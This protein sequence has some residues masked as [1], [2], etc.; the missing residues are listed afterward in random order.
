MG[1]SASQAR[2]LSITQRLSDN[3]LHSEILANSKMRLADESIAA[4]NEYLSA[5]DATKIQYVGFDGYGNADTVDLTFNSLMTYSEIK[6]QNVL[7]NSNGQ[8][9]I[10]ETDLYNFET[11]ADMY[12]FVS[13][14]C[15]AD[16]SAYQAQVA[17]YGT[18]QSDYDTWL[19]D[20]QLY[21]DQ[22][23]QY[24]AGLIPDEPTEPPYPENPG[25]PVM[26]FNNK[27]LAQ[28]YINLWHAIDGQEN[29]SE[30]TAQ[31]DDNGVFTYYTVENKEKQTQYNASGVALNPAYQVIPDELRSDA[32]WLNHALANGMVSVNQIITDSNANILVW[33]G[34]DYT[35]TTSF[36]EVADNKKVAK[37]EAEYQS[38]MKR[39]ENEDS[40]I[41]LKIKKLDTEHSALKTEYESI[42]QLL[43]KNIERSYG[44]FN[45]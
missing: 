28:W 21:L 42:S 17:A 34:I 6:N 33:T 35:S 1:L 41:D 27:P 22:L 11:S 38:E 23:D 18:Y 2:L 31:Y 29:P 12:E 16:Y 24:Q 19:S 4:K 37:A 43:G 36:S 20:Y 32:N 14:Y 45:A 13:R 10:S 7:K 30:L 39:I 15:D 8:V 5:L 25:E 40:K 44:I 3:E 26:P 9:L